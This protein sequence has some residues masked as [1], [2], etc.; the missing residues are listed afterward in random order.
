M[1][2]PNLCNVKSPQSQ[3]EM[4]T[5]LESESQIPR[6]SSWAH[7]WIC[8]LSMDGKC[9]TKTD[10]SDIL[11]LACDVTTYTEHC[12]GSGSKCTPL[13]RRLSS[14]RT[15]QSVVAGLCLR[16]LRGP[17]HRD[18]ATSNS[19][20]TPIQDIWLSSCLCHSP[21]WDFGWIASPLLASFFS[22]TVRAPNHIRDVV[23]IVIHE[24]N[25]L[26]GQWQPEVPCWDWLDQWVRSAWFQSEDWW[27][28]APYCLTGL[29]KSEGN[30]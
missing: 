8:I 19:Y 18:N 1:G 29:H 10:A 26:H 30:I 13:G 5:E 23:I 2:R 25:V 14:K 27:H 22:V 28:S 21:G 15:Y 17:I 3:C 24:S 7:S 12:R 20:R 16:G 4:R 9:M 6:Y 11:W